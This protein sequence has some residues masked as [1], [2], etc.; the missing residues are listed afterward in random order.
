MVLVAT[1]QEVL[2]LRT[3]LAAR[4]RAARDVEVTLIALL[5]ARGH[6]T[7]KFLRIVD[8]THIDLEVPE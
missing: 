5:A 7:G 8:D 3:V 4:D 2:N 6:A 1:V